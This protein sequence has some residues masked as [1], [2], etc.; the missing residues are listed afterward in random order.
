[1]EEVAISPTIEPPNRQSTNWKTIVSKKLSHVGKVLGPTTDPQPGD[2]AKGL[3]TPREFDFEGQWDLI[4]EFPQDWR[5]LLEGT[6]KT[7]FL[8]GTRRK[9]QRSHNR[10]S[11]TWLCVS[12][13]LL[14]RHGS[15]VVC[16][17]ISTE[18][19]SPGSSKNKCRW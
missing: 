7:L 17:G 9:K 2:L 3:R 18:Y 15:M 5:R 8:P 6:S 14:Q 16:R 12:R 10:L 4:T 13:N 11:Q 19:T 1:M